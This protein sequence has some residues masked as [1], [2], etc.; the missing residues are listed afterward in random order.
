MNGISLT[1]SEFLALPIKQQNTVLFQNVQEIKV[2]VS[3]WKFR[4]KL[5]ISWL[6]SITAIGTYFVIKLIE[7]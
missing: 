2:L 6:A 7:S 3:G 1:E 5:V 4:Q